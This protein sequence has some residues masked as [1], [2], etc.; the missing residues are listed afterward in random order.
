L[1]CPI[2]IL[3]HLN[4]FLTCPV[5][6]ANGQCKA[7]LPKLSFWVLSEL[8]RLSRLSGLGGLSRSIVLLLRRTEQEGLNDLI[9]NKQKQWVFFFTFSVYSHFSRYPL[10]GHCPFWWAH[11]K[12]HNPP[13]QYLCTFSHKKCWGG[14]QANTI[15]SSMPNGTK[16]CE[17]HEKH[18]CGQCINSP[19]SALHWCRVPMD[20]M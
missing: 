16:M 1:T 9:V 2:Q 3:H 5:T 12:I 14:A 8:S 6:S 13:Q 18:S 11:A 4:C 10:L 7:S 15:L 20:I 17:Q 19:I